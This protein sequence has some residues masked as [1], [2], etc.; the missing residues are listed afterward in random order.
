M[1]TKRIAA[2]SRFLVG[3]VIVVFVGIGTFAGQAYGAP[4][5]SPIE[6][7]GKQIFFDEISKPARMACALCHSPSAGWTHRNPLV[8]M[9][10][11]AAPGA[12]IFRSGTLKTPTNAYASFIP[13]FQPCPGVGFLQ[14]L[15]GKFLGRAC[16]R[17]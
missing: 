17:E 16:R 4:K 14:P 5:L 8:N 6:E 3:T 9:Y 11:V 2:W 15:R 13:P 1:E 10:Q 12:V 7:L